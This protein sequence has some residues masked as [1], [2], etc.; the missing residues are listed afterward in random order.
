MR[1]RRQKNL[2]GQICPVKFTA[3]EAAWVGQGF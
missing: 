1:A 3:L 2:E